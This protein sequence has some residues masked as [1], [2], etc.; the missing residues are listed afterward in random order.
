VPSSARD[1]KNPP[2]LDRLRNE[3]K[4]L[5]TCFGGKGQIGNIRRLNWKIETTPSLGVMCMVHCFGTGR[6]FLSKQR[7]QTQRCRACREGVSQKTTSARHIN[8]LRSNG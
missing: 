4:D 1:Q 7:T 5:D 8:R 3:V 2:A 6:S